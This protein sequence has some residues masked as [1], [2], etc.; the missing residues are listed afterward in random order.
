MRHPQGAV[1]VWTRRSTSSNFN[2]DI[3]VSRLSARRL[4]DA[5]VFDLAEPLRDATAATNDAGEILLAGDAV[6]R[7][8]T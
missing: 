2:D 5:A 8:A 7:A 1:A 4:G 6:R 3:V